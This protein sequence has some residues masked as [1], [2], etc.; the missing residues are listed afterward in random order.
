M[1]RR[2]RAHE[3][4]VGMTDRR[5]VRAAHDVRRRRHGGRGHARHRAGAAAARPQACARHDAPDADLAAARGL[6]RPAAGRP[7]CHRDDAGAP[8]LSRDRA[9]RDPRD[10]HQPAARRRAGVIAL[11]ARVRVAGDARGS[12]PP[13]R[14][15]GPIRCNGSG[16]S[17]CRA[18]AT[19]YCARSGPR[20]STSTAG[21]SR[22]STAEDLRMRFFTRGPDL[23]HRLLARLTQIDYARE[24]AFVAIDR[25][26]GELL[27][28]V[29]PD[30]RSRL[31]GA[32]NTR[33][34][35]LPTSRGAGSAG[36]SCST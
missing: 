22:G 14:R 17:P 31:T 7:R 10:R 35:S 26:A 23:S 28:V 27:G 11:D 3:L 32:R 16:G 13:A 8:Q 4:I 5:D 29:A 2:P 30:R 15:S 21:S 6:S 19:C 1:I 12:A 34:S 25:R 36:G 18:W 33:S 20:T 9:P 24:M